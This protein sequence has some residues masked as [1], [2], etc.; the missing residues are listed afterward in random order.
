MNKATRPLTHLRLLEVLRYEPSTGKCF[1]LVRAAHRRQPGEEAGCPSKD[2]RIRISIDNQL[3]Y[4]YRLAWLYMTGNWPEHGID[5]RNGDAT[6]DRWENL[7]DVPQ[8]LN[9]QNV[10]RAPKHSTTGLLGA[11]RTR[12]GTFAAVIRIGKERRHLGTF[13]T[14]DAA[15]AAYLNAKRLHHAGNTL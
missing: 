9:V 12:D 14:A 1:W 4:R 10:R 6:D 2:G 5:H 3:Y 13:K 11:Q 7:R 8:A 15:H